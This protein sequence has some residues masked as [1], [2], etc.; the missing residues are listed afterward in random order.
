MN[1]PSKKL[2]PYALKKINAALDAFM[3]VVSEDEH[4]FIG[5]LGIRKGLA[6]SSFSELQKYYRTPRKCIY[7]KC[8]NQSVSYSH[9]I[10][11]STSL[12]FI[13]ENQHVLSPELDIQNMSYIM[14][15]VG[16]N[17]ASALPIFCEHHEKIFF[18]FENDGIIKS[19]EHVY[20]QVFRA[21]CR[22]IVLKKLQIKSLDDYIEKLRKIITKNG[23]KFINERLGEEFISKHNV[24]LKSLTFTNLSEGIAVAEN[25]KKTLV[26]LLNLLEN[27]FFP[28]SIMEIEN[29]GEGLAHYSIVIKA[30]S[31]V[32]LSG[33][34]NFTI[35]DNGTHHN[36]HAI[37]NIIPNPSRTFLSITVSLKHKE[38]LEGYLAQFLNHFNGPLNL[39]ETWM[40]NGPDHWFIKPSEWNA[41]PDARKQKILNEILDESV[42][43]G[44]HYGRSIIDTI[45]LKSLISP[46]KN[47][48]PQSEIQI[49]RQKYEED[50]NAVQFH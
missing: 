2:S 21:I 30:D 17:T 14:K 45:R 36:V 10:S 35:N 13:S 33:L 49:E 20:L 44:S 4:S 18:V 48:Y 42:N 16:V 6:F 7:P 47:D 24:N 40:V 29:N 15:S 19:D 11:K 22:E 12:K 3:D 25:S 26:R 5:K 28:N 50:K 23:I 1:T 41:I 27:D 43:I 9:T 34:A 39:I 8:K 37:L 32:C 31:P 46:E 38:Y